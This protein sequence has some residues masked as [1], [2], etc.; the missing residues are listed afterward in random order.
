MRQTRATVRLAAFAALLAGACGPRGGTPDAG[1]GDVP[2]GP[3]CDLTIGPADRISL[4]GT[5]AA[6]VR[7]RVPGGDWTLYEPLGD[8][9]VP[10]WYFPF[11]RFPTSDRDVQLTYRRRVEWPAR[12]GCVPAAESG[13]RALVELDSADYAA[14][15]R[16]DRRVLGTHTGYLGRFAVELPWGASGDVVV[17]LDDLVRDVDRR[18]GMEAFPHVS[19]Q[20]ADTGGWGVNPVGLPGGVRLRLVRRTYLRAAYAAVV[21]RDGDRATVRLGLATESFAPSGRLAAEVAVVDPSGGVIAEHTAPVVPDDRGEA[22][23]EVEVE[24]LAP[25]APGTVGAYEARITLT[26]DGEIADERTVPVA[27]RIVSLGERSLVVDGV[28]RFA[29]GAA[30]HHTYRFAPFEDG[31]VEGTY[32]AADADLERAYRDVVGQARAA[33]VEWLRLGHIVPDPLFFRVAREEGVFVAQDLPLHWNTDFDALPPD[34][35]ARQAREL[36]WRVAAEP[37]VALVSLHNE[38][39]FLEDDAGEIET[40]QQLIDDLHDVA[41]AVAPHLVAVGCSG[42][43]ATARF[44]PDD[45]YPVADAISDAHAYYGSWWSP[46]HGWASIPSRV[47][48][49]VD[50]ATRP[51]LWSEMGNGWTRHYV[52]L[53]ALESDLEPASPPELAALRRSLEPWLVAPDGRQLDLAQFYALAYCY[54]ELGTPLAE[55]EACV[56]ATLAERTDADHIAW[57]RAYFLGDRLA[58][59]GDPADPVTAGVLVA[60]HWLAA[61][62]FASR[63]QW[64]AGAG[65]LGTFAWERPENAYPA[66][67]NGAGDLEIPTAALVRSQTIAAAANAP[68]AASVS[69]AGD[70]AEIR[71]VNDGA[72]ATFDLELSTGGG[73]PWRT[74]LAVPARGGG[75]AAVPASALVGAGGRVVSVRVA[76]GGELVAEAA[77][78]P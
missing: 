69:R 77:F 33:G 10:G 61:Q 4:D 28:E 9:T 70:G 18:G 1:D 53:A 19:L 32:V 62:I 59:E 42:C 12:W 2:D 25:P 72:A 57:A 48:G 37:A 71:V 6:A 40:C 76:R 21:S 51:V 73:E 65:F 44:P 16:L 50:G 15:V 8:V 41:R 27:D 75:A 34:E 74:S 13:L 26:S 30:I 20:G 11:P 63:W 68:V 23:A 46:S 55:L 47:A 67:P 66:A 52:Y 43:R 39:E 38:A 45:A 24:S 56:A 31:Y 54:E 29:R 78:V 17:D 5:W 49:L 22:F 64:A 3:P 58:V 60:A 7:T 14:S 35:I 36:V